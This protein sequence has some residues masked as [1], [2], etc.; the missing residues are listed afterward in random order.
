MRR[1]PTA[2][3][4]IPLAE[5]ATGVGDCGT[6]E[7]AMGPEAGDARPFDNVNDYNGLNLA[8]ITDITGGPVPF[9]AGYTALVAVAPVAL[10]GIT[11]A[12]GDA[13]RITVTVTAPTGGTFALDG[14]R[15]R[16]APNA[17]P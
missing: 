6:P 15:T 1:L 5:T 9:L 13:L 10:N 16:Y 8:A 11:V 17:L 7:S 2:T 12:S 4:T 14:Y 3:R